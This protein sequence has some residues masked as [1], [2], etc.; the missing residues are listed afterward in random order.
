[1]CNWGMSPLGPISYGENQDTVFLGREITRSHNVSE[2]TAHLIDLEVKK[3]VDESYARSQKIILGHR[4][5][6]D[7]IAQ[8]LLE[9]ETIEGKHVKELVQFGELR[10]PVTREAITPQLKSDDRGNKKAHEKVS[11]D[12]LGGAAPSPH[13]A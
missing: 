8:A 2:E 6:L 1:V 4:V 12:P 5:A 9:H 11:P 10:S 13:P 3:L 7:K